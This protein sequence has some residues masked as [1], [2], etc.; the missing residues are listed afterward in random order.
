[1]REGCQLE[2]SIDLPVITLDDLCQKEKIENIDF[3]Q[4]DVQ[5]ADLDV[6][7]G[8]IDTLQ[9]TVVAIEIEVEFSPLY[10]DQ[11][12]FADVDRF[13]RR[14]GFIFFD[15]HT[16]D[17][18]CRRPRAISPIHSSRRA[19][20][21]LWGNA[22]YFRDP[23]VENS[24]P[25]A[26]EPANIVKLACIADILGYYDYAIELLDY[27]TRH[28]GQDPVY[29]FAREIIATLE[30]FPELVE[31]GLDNLPIVTNLRPFLLQNP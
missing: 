11:P 2:F 23:L 13:L 12:L 10:Q 6:L 17:P 31:R 30:Q 18:W 20:Q 3:L 15:L 28:H 21:L 29:N 8:A 7:Q 16:D 5:G 1:M 27:L 25:V 19:G 26:R 9:E 24:H 14:E 4:I 22:L